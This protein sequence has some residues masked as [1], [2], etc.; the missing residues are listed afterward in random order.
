MVYSLMCGALTESTALSVRVDLVG[1]LPLAFCL[2]L[3]D[4]P[5]AL[6]VLLAEGR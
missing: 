4:N 5:E 1:N 3:D 6:H 2:P